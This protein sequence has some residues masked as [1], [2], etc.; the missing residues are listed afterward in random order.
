MTRGATSTFSPSIK[1][2]AAKTPQPVELGAKKRSHICH[3]SSW[4]VSNVSTFPKTE[5][6]K[7][8]EKTVTSICIDKRLSV[9]VSRDV[10]ALDVELYLLT[11]CNVVEF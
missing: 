2:R 7:L 4:V 8:M 6:R 3:G 10:S 1:S 11:K 5:R 9:D